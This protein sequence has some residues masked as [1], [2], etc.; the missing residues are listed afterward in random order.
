[1]TLAVWQSLSLILVVLCVGPLF[2]SAYLLLLTVAAL[3]GRRRSVAAGPGGRR[4]AVLVPAHNEELLLGRLL[5]SLREIDYPPALVDIY[6][7]ADNCADKTAQIARAGGAHV[8]ERFN[9]Q[10]QGKGHA[11]RW[12]LGELRSPARPCD[13][14]VVLDA[15]SVVA[16]NFLRAMDARLEAGS[17]VIQAFYTVLNR[18]ESPVASLRF[19][20]LAAVHYLRP[21]GRTAL[22]LSC[23]LKGNGMCFAAPV[24]E[25][26]AWRWF[27]LAEDVEFHLALVREGILVDFAP[28]TFVQAEMPVSLRQSATQNARWEQGRLQLVRQHVPHLLWQGFRRR[29]LMRLD[30]AAEQCIPPLSVPFALGAL[31]LVC[32]LFVGSP[33]ALALACVSLGTQVLYLL[34]GLVLVRAPWRVYAALAY[35]PVYVSWKVLLYGQA[36]IT[37]QSDRWI[38]T[39]RTAA[40]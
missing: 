2:V 8:Y 31:C 20:A 24:L 38:R 14:F 16:P 9:T 36:L 27:A 15:D 5:N 25:R 1:M 22:R 4:F 12:L 34:V 7:V 33:L 29:S 3:A 11:L 23:G 39:P 35:A 32:A 28:E 17:E 30:A 40:A 37:R 19:A 18:V 13:A 21:L 26:F 6:V 10:E